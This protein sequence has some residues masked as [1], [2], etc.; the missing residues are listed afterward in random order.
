MILSPRQVNEYVDMTWDW[1]ERPI[2]VAD[3][4]ILGQWLASY[5]DK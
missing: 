1:G 2:S 5:Y 4:L 3:S